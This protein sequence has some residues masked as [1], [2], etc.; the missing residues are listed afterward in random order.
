MKGHIASRSNLKRPLAVCVCTHAADV[1]CRIQAVGE[2][3]I[4][5]RLI[6]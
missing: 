1:Y 4:N 5:P 3:L 2:R 6:M